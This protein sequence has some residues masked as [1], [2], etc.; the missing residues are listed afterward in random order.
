MGRPKKIV[1][2]DNDGHLGFD[3]ERQRVLNELGLMTEAELA[4]LYD[5]GVRAMKNRPR[6][7]LPP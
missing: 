1:E 6:S 5:C 2:E 3:E 4:L 7:E